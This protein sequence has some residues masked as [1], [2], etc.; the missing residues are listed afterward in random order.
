MRTE[1]KSNGMSELSCLNIYVRVCFLISAFTLSA[2][3][4]QGPQ[5]P[6]TFQVLLKTDHVQP[7][8]GSGSV[9]FLRL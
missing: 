7:T 5:T 4:K 6:R 3:K 9:G 1:V 8:A 2:F